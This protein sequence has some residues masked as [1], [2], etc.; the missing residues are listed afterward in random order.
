MINKFLFDM[1]LRAKLC[2]VFMCIIML[3]YITSKLYVIL[4]IC[5]VVTCRIMVKYITSRLYVMLYYLHVM[6]LRAQLC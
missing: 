3:K 4:P 5:Y 2:Y 6:P 1:C